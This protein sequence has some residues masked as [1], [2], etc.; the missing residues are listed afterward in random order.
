M[1]FSALDEVQF[2]SHIA[3]SL[4][5]SHVAGH[6][7]RA[8]SAIAIAIAPP[9]GERSRASLLWMGA[10]QSCEIVNG[11]AGIAR[12]RILTAPLTTRSER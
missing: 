6:H 7:V 9:R 4:H 11:I 2:T 3:E 12:R 1:K 5:D 10:K 8:L